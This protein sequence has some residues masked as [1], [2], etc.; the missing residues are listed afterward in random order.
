MSKAPC[1]FFMLLK[2]E[3]RYVSKS[4]VLKENDTFTIYNFLHH[5]LMLVLCVECYLHMLEFVKIC[6]MQLFLDYWFEEEINSS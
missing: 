1:S 2:G 3:K 5:S 4:Y 6:I